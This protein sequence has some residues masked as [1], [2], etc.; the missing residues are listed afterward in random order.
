MKKIILLRHAKSNHTPPGLEDFD[1]NLNEKGLEDLNK[2]SEFLNSEQFI[3]EKIYCSSATRTKET[4]ETIISEIKTPIDVEYSM[5]L[6]LANTEV[7]FNKIKGTNRDINTVMVVGH[8]PGIHDLVLFLLKNEGSA[9]E[10]EL[11]GSFPTSALAI[12]NF[13]CEEWQNLGPSNCT[14]EHFKIPKKN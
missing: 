3:P 14:L 5:N 2:V 11:Y 10:R 6:Y 1:R 13:N 12:L 4:C 7:L 9:S 8:N